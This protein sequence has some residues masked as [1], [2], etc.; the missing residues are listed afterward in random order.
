MAN[1]MSLVKLYNSPKREGFDL[2]RKNI[3]SAK[4]GECLPVY[5][6]PVLPGDKFKL[7]TKHFTRTAPLN[8]AAYARMNEYFDWYFVPTNLLWNRFNTFVSQMKDNGQ[9]ADSITMNQVLDD[10]HPFISRHDVHDYLERVDRGQQYSYNMFGFRR[11]CVN[12]KLLEYLGYGRFVNE[13]DEL[14]ETP[15]SPDYAMNP[16]PLLG[17]QKI[18]FDHIRDSQ[19]EKSYAPAFNINYMNG[20]PSSNKKLPIS[21]IGEEFDSMFEMRYCNWKKDYFMGVL[22]N[23]QYGDVAS[24]NISSLLSGFSP[25][26][27]FVLKSDSETTGNVTTSSGGYLTN[28]T[29]NNWSLTASGIDKIASSLGIKSGSLIGTFSILALRN[30]EALQ[31]W[32]EITQSHQ[33]DYKSQMEAHWG[34]HVS[35]AYSERSVYIGGGKATIDINPI[36]NQNLTN[37]EEKPI[38]KGMGTGVSEDYTDFSSDVHGYLFCI[39]HCAPDVDYAIEGI[40]KEMLKTYVTDYAIPELDHTGMVQMP[41]AELSMA[42]DK[43]ALANGK[44][45]LLGYAPRYYEYKTTY[46][47]VHGVFLKSYKNWVAPINEEYIYRWLEARGS[48]SV[49]TDLLDFTFFKVTPSVLDEIFGYAANSKTESDQFFVNAFFDVKVVRNLDRNGLPY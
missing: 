40:H 28:G 12:A 35:D 7:Q 46:D 16:F 37:A 27:N 22:P 49:G 23:S 47:E 24:V 30:A 26:S 10:Q 1:I 8:S 9:Q 21:Q 32:A 41:L 33:Q 15:N 5:M 3:F 42:F 14:F 45:R 17:Y 18:Y 2:S 36:V 44:S 11:S 19:W 13:N 29:S 34:V 39:Y 6:Q 4:A 31:K 48:V 25:T 20:A 43:I 38:I